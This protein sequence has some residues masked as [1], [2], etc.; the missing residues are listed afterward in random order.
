MKFLDTLFVTGFRKSLLFLLFV[1][2]SATAFAGQT[3]KLKGKII[4]AQT[5][6][7]VIGANIFIQGT[8][9]GAASDV[10]GNFIVAN[11]PPGEYEVRITCMG[12]QNTLVKKVLI[13]IDLTT[14][15]DV[16]LSPVTLQLKEEVVVT[17]N[18]PMVQKD[19]TS[20]NSIVTGSELKSLP[21]ENISQVVNLQAGVVDG[22][23]R[24]G[25]SGE[26]AY[27]VDGVSVTDAF[28]G[29][30]SLRIENNSIRQM[31]VISGTFNAEYGQAMSGV[32]NI[33][34][35]DGSTKFEGFVNTY[36]GNFLTSH[37][38]IFR[39]LDKPARLASKDIQVG[40]SGPVGLKGLTFF[41]TFRAFESDGYLY[42]QRIYKVTDDV[43]IV[44]S[45]TL[46]I[47]RNTGDK[48]FV[49]MNPERHFSFNGKLTYAAQGYKISYGFFAD[50]NYNRY[51]DHYFSWTPD[52]TLKHYRQNFVHNLQFTYIPDAR[53]LHSLKFSYN[54][55]D[56]KGYLYEDMFD[57]INYVDPTR[58]IPTS[59]YTFRSGGNDGSRYYRTTR[60]ML[61]QYSFSSQIS[62]E[63]KIG[64]GAELR[65]HNMFNH[66]LSIANLKEGQV[67]SNN[68]KLFQLGYPNLGTITDNAYNIMY[69]KKP[70]EFSAYIQDKM[71]Y[72]ILIIN[73]GIRFDYFDPKTQ[74]PADLKNLTKNPDFPGAN[75]FNNVKAKYQ[76]SPRIGAS[77]PITDEGIIRFSYG[78]FFQ[79]PSFENLYNNPDFIIRPG[80]SLS[81][82][83]GNPDL[84]AQKTVMYEV[85]LQQVLFNSLAVN[86]SFYSRDIRNLLGMEI[87]NTY[88]GFKYARYINRDYGNV[89][90]FLLMLDKRLSDMVSFKVDYTYQ[91]AEGNASDPMAVYNNNQ[92]VPPVEESKKVLPLNWDQRHTLN[93][94]L[95]VGQ[96]GDWNVGFIAQYGSGTPYTED[97][98]ISQG[99]RFENGGV[100]PTTFNVDMRADK[101]FNVGGININAFLLVYNLFDIKNE[102]GV[103]GTTG[104]A[105]V[106]LN[107][108]Y[109]GEI[110]GINT[111]DQYV[112]NPGMYSRPREIRIGFGFGY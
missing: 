10:E 110:I 56:Y 11:I 40:L 19:M 66:S 85:G 42:G 27:L 86:L 17:A 73:A 70:V 14:V 99:V 107:T 75:Q 72:D 52:G 36:A 4:D 6:E 1:V 104:R 62:N 60:T 96:F 49:P 5:K 22:H 43:P 58:G 64:I 34:T 54:T 26:V 31:E 71:E 108:K 76:F 2:L 81:S 15:I 82:I 20:T 45:P 24:G 7:P 47:P 13:K 103:Y 41:S 8:Y 57:T 55:H 88:E 48:A 100:K 93:L 63:H 87:I 69:T 21:V 32:V 67:D 35:Q 101:N 79:I 61:A 92:S 91:V 80:Q 12:Y 83:T 68:V 102:Y 98:K 46:F 53:S 29:S 33:V 74:L 25:R 38:D 77:F 37:S 44:V 109:A 89:R 90:G 28:N 65:M 106:D 111:I 59:G 95:N 30:M 50:D 97:V 23:F 94:S 16:T 78:H 84:G 39:N 51:Y 18:K 3:G 105:G 9:L 112:N